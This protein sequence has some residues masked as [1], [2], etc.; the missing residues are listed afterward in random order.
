M[1][2]LFMATLFHAKYIN[3]K[4][5]EIE[6]TIS[7]LEIETDSI[8]ERIASGSFQQEVLEEENLE[9]AAKLVAPTV[10]QIQDGNY[11]GSGSILEIT[12]EN[13]I[14][15][16]NQHVIQDGR[17]ATV[18]FFD[19]FSA[20]GNVVSIS[21]NE[22]LA[23]IQVNNEMV[24]EATLLALK[25]VTFN[26]ERYDSLEQND[27]MFFVG[28]SEAVGSDIIYGRIGNMWW[29]LADFDTYV[30]Y[31]Y[32]EVKE[33]MSGSGTFDSYGNYIGMLVGGNQLEA[34]SIPLVTIAE[35]YKIAFE[36]E[37]K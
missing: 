22:D 17:E 1:G 20:V 4:N 25:E 15:I 23:F 10:V 30:I 27:S 36:K 6:A 7:I 31:T 34:A 21:E 29:Y 5:S 35:E 14:I 32:C 26:Q 18:I 24:E 9:E 37:L 3:N 2:G 11:Q 28:S 19:G 16:S 13:M 33:G 8:Q 12:Q